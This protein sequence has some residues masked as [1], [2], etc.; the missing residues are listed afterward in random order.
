LHSALYPR[1]PRGGPTDLPPEYAFRFSFCCA[2]DGCRRRATPASVRF[3]G[4]H[5]YLGAVIVLI[6]ALAHGSTPKRVAYLRDRVGG[7]SRQTVERWR[8]WWREVFPATT[9][10]RGLRGRL[11]PPVAIDELPGSLLDRVTA[12]E[13]SE[14]L[15][16]VMRLL[17]PITTTSVRPAARA[18]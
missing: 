13:P 12:A 7:V 10:F 18:T 15:V 9:F 1:K 5:I 4:R 8:R 16:A 17:S 6:T 14:S 2:R 3:L 11:F